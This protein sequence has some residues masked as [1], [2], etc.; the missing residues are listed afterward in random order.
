MPLEAERLDDNVRSFYEFQ[1]KHNRLRL[2]PHVVT[3]VCR[4]TA[5]GESGWGV[6]VQLGMDRYN[7]AIF[8]YLALKYGYLPEKDGDEEPFA[9]EMGKVVD[10]AIRDLKMISV[11]EIVSLYGGLDGN[12]RYGGEVSEEFL[13]RH[14][15]LRTSDYTLSGT[16]LNE[17]TFRR[18]Y[19]RI[20]PGNEDSDG[21][22]LRNECREN[23]LS[24]HY[25][26]N[27][28]SIIPS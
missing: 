15:G 5:M 9:S 21:I 12:I 27:P 24:V 17:G 2:L 4:G 18:A 3:E 10:M 6:S 16:N 8:H 20:T 14:L 11:A 7:Y 1:S 26:L 23:C 28:S 25:L 13:Q 22:I 19:F